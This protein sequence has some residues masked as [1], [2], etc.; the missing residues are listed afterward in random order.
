MDVAVITTRLVDRDAQGNFTEAT[1]IEL[2]K[3]CRKVVLYT[4]AWERQPLDVVEIQFLGGEN[5]HSIAAN[6]NALMK[7]GKLARE[8]AAYDLLVLAGPDVGVLPAISRAKR[9]NPK[10]RLVWVYH[11]LTPVEFLP[12]AKD[13]WLTRLR[14]A[15]YV[16]S[17]KGSDLVKTDS[18]FTK[19]ELEQSGI[20]PEKIVAIP[21]GIDLQRFSPGPDD[22][23]IRSKYDACDR[24]VLLYVGRL[25]QGKRVDRLLNTV[26]QMNDD[27]IMLIVV[28]SGPESDKLEV[29]AREL[30][31]QDRVRF[32]GRVPDAE[33]PNY[34]RA[35]DAWVTASDHEGFC[36]PVL[37]AMATGKPVIVPD[38]AAMPETAGEA[39]IVYKPG[40]LIDL[41]AGIRRLMQDNI[42]YETLA[43]RACANAHSFD[44]DSV[45]PEY[46]NLIMNGRR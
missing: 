41:A 39:A 7:T 29:L 24:F 42:Y 23:A 18:Q 2:K 22:R 34:Y 25:A 12:A 9:L 44:I 28:G 10:L 3:L 11:G 35:C 38:T 26:A 27:R 4:F 43:K 19:K 1:L 16:R 36:V 30:G 37:E 32:A 21:L 8:F 40:D 17:M 14:K 15:A 46:M 13:R 5:R 33:L 20:E 45:M 31:L 6:I